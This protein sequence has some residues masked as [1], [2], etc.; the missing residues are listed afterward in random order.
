MFRL[1]LLMGKNQTFLLHTSMTTYLVMMKIL[2]GSWLYLYACADRP[3]QVEADPLSVNNATAENCNKSRFVQEVANPAPLALTHFDTVTIASAVKIPSVKV[4][5]VFLSNPTRG[6]WI[7]VRRPLA[8]A[9]VRHGISKG[10]C[11]FSTA[12]DC[13]QM[14]AVFFPSP[15]SF[16]SHPNQMN[17]W[18]LRLTSSYVLVSFEWPRH[19]HRNPYS[20]H[21]HQGQAI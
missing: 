14:V 17:F 8:Q 2:R 18:Q 13:T 9:P 20:S 3:L 21:L 15:F 6:A 11:Y 4:R 7:H 19:S 10:A 5:F 1:R 12:C 16:V